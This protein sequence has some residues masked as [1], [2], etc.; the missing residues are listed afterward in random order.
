MLNKTE[1][2]N[3]AVVVANNDNAVKGSFSLTDIINATH[4]D[5]EALE[6]FAKKR[7][8]WYANEKRVLSNVDGIKLAS[9]GVIG[10]PNYIALYRGNKSQN[11]YGV[12]YNTL[13]RK[14]LS[15][16]PACKIAISNA[17]KGYNNPQEIRVAF[18]SLR[19][20]VAHLD[21]MFEYI[22]AYNA[23]T[24]EAVAHEVVAK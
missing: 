6:T 5:F 16:V 10:T 3:V 8:F 14:Q 22:K 7:G 19:D 20:A 15:E 1:N 12:R 18:S 11:S 13:A 24:V 17:Q 23:D 2:N 21:L 9:K 4:D